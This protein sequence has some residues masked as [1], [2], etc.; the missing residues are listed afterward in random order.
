MSL[1]DEALASAAEEPTPFKDVSTELGGKH[2]P[3]RFYALDGEKWSEIIAFCPARL[4]SAIDRRYGY[5]FQQAA[6]MAAPLCG[7][8]VDQGAE[9]PITD[10]QWDDL[11]KRLKGH[12]IKLIH[13]AIWELNEYDPEVRVATAK[14]DSA[15]DSPQKPS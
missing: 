15:A 8:L 9:I 14:K 5:N 11:F 1:L 6:R 7:R 3:F 4:G 2:L 12:S 10:D 13:S